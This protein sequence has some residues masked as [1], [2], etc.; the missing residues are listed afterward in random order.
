MIPRVAKR[1]CQQSIELIET[2][3]GKKDRF[4]N[5][6]K[7]TVRA[8]INNVVVQE[9]TV[10]SGTNNSRQIT[11]NATIFM[12]AGVTTPLPHFDKSYMGRK[13]LYEGN[14]Y[15]ITNIVKN[16]EPFSNKVYSYEIEVL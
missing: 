7:T 14:E 11:A 10:Y 9:G 16:K 3:E 6:K 13:L 15:T 8:L 4:G 1:F 12:Y 5:A 2:Q